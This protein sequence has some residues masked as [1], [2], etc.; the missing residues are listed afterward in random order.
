MVHGRRHRA[1]GAKWISRAFGRT[2][3][4]GPVALYV[5]PECCYTGNAELEC[6]SGF[7]KAESPEVSIGYNIFQRQKRDQ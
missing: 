4:Q 6:P 2:E 1:K 3:F 5:P 7:W